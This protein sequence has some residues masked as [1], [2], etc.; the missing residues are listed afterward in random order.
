[1]YSAKQLTNVMLLIMVICAVVTAQSSTTV[2]VRIQ[3]TPN[4][5]FENGLT[6]DYTSSNLWQNRIHFGVAYASSRLGS[7]IGS[8]ALKQD[9]ILISSALHFRQ[10]KQVNPILGLNLGY[11]KVDTEYEIF[12]MLPNSSMLL[13]L[14][15]GARFHVTNLISIQTTLGY[16]LIAG[17]GIDGPGTLYPIFL[18]FSTFY[19]LNGGK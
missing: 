1:M 2:G 8:N 9:N 5:Y 12:S 6:F 13:S 16:N 15:L 19:H 18:N 11:F 3:K 14:E 10:G 17:N 7:A 4:L